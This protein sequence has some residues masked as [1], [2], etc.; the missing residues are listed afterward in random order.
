MKSHDIAL[1][2]SFIRVFEEGG[3]P[4]PP[5]LLV[6]GFIGTANF[7]QPVKTELAKTRRV[8]SFDQRG[9]GASGPFTAALSM[10]Q[11]T[12]D[13]VA[14]LATA[15][16]ACTH[17]IGHSAGA[18]VGMMLA[19]RVPSLVA[20][21]TLIGAWTKADLWM[22][23]VFQTRLDSLD[24]KGALAYLEA[25]TLFMRPPADLRERSASLLDEEQRAL[26]NFPGPTGTRARADAV[27][28]WDSAPFATK[29]AC[30]TLV[31]GSADDQMTPFYFSEQLAREI[32]GASLHRLEQGGHYCVRS[33]PTETLAPIRAFL[34]AS[35]ARM[36]G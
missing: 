10:E 29:V 17:V 7:W 3:G 4:L 19:E 8:I 24:S 6:S 34:S 13:A 18:G 14:V 35:D 9:T 16:S 20:S 11:M 21:L 12:Q 1:A 31:V 30:P 28:A 36:A 5:V 23:R 33:R 32:P 2:D 25:T 27:L 15:G 26:L 22:K